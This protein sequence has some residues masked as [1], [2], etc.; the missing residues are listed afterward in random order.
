[1]FCRA[2][3]IRWLVFENFGMCTDLSL[4]LSLSLAP[5]LSLVLSF[6]FC[7]HS[8]ASSYTV[9]RTLAENMLTIYLRG[10]ILGGA[11]AV[12]QTKPTVHRPTGGAATFDTMTF[13]TMALCAKV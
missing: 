7:S 13:G 4:S 11:C 9:A 6:S 8:L 2:D 12:T 5:S 3:K 10:K 1:M